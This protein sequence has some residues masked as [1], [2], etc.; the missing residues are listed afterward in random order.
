MN[1]KFVSRFDFIGGQIMDHLKFI[2]AGLAAAMIPALFSGCAASDRSGGVYRASAD[3][4]SKAVSDTP[5]REPV[6]GIWVTPRMSLKATAE[7]YNDAYRQVKEAGINTVITFDESSSASK[8]EK[9]LDACSE[10]GL[11]AIVTLPRPAS[12]S[13]IRS[14]LNIVQRFDSHPAVIGYNLYD[15]PARDAFEIIANEYEEIRAN[16]SSDKIILINFYPNYVDPGIIDFKN[17]G[18]LTW[19]QNYLKTFFDTAKSDVVCFDNYPYRA[20]AEADENNISLLIANLCDIAALG[21]QK[22]LPCWGF[23][24]CGEWSGTRTPDLGELRFLSNL[25]LLFGLKGYTYFLYVTPVDGETSE[26][27]FKGMVNYDGSKTKT[28]ELV[29]RVNNELDGMKGVYLDYEFKGIIEKD[30]SETLKNSISDRY[31]LQ[32]FGDVQKLATDGTVLTGCFENENGKKALYVLNYDSHNDTEVKIT[33]KGVTGFRLWSKAGI[34]EM[35]ADK[36]IVFTLSLGEG[37]FI[38]LG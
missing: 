38:E 32:G 3:E 37:K 22:G 26:G 17:E 4:I 29:Q 27:V 14:I 8:M 10:N 13:Q 7:D 28:Y 15:E 12:S 35:G 2:A 31:R 21:E 16:C 19:Y 33:F 9:C 18:E 25:H 11:N 5:F 23:V 30:L 6:R 36:E 20:A 34:E 24:Q 1:A